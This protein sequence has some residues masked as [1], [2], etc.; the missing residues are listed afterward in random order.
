M[1]GLL[2]WDFKPGQAIADQVRRR[3]G[4][5]VHFSPSNGTNE[6][7]LVVFFSS[8]SFPLS[9]EFVGIALQCCIGG[10]AEGFSISQLDDRK[11][12][13]SVASNRVGH[14]IYHLKDR[15]SPD[16]VCHFSLYRPERHATPRVILVGIRIIIWQSYLHANQWRLNT[17]SHLIHGLLLLILLRCLN[18]QKLVFLIKNC[19]HRG[20]LQSPECCRKAQHRLEPHN[21]HPFRWIL[22][23]MFQGL[24]QVM[25]LMLTSNLVAFMWETPNRGVETRQPTNIYC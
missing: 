12:H 2:H 16:F 3:F 6:F 15:I 18:W 20:F 7:F 17:H 1:D 8:A 11:F 4:S 22:A 21:G 10:S 5:T 9:V 23:L 19:A 14:F 13:F 24:F 25:H